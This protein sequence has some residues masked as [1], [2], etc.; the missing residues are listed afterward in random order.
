MPVTKLSS[1]A[2][3]EPM[4]DRVSL[5]GSVVCEKEQIIQQLG[6]RVA[7]AQGELNSVALQA[8]AASQRLRQLQEHLVACPQR[9][10][11]A[12]PAVVPDISA[13]RPRSSLALDG[14]V[15]AA[16]ER[17]QTLRQERSELTD[18]LEATK[19]QLSHLRDA[20]GRALGASAAQSGDVL[21]HS[22]AGAEMRSKIELAGFVGARSNV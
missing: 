19:G 2:T 4:L 3:S 12:V 21:V 9:R 6:G 1:C 14:D 8:S 16:Q 15:H 17:L 18:K 5:V 11:A 10:E 20:Q 22:L 13:S 7:E